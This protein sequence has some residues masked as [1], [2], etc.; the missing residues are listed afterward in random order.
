MKNFLLAVGKMCLYTFVISVTSSLVDWPL[1]NS[2]GKGALL[3]FSLGMLV[4]VGTCSLYLIKEGITSAWKI[5]TGASDNSRVSEGAYY[6]REQVKKPN[7]LMGLLGYE[8]FGPIGGL[9][10]LNYHPDR[11]K[12]VVIDEKKEVIL[13]VNMSGLEMEN[14]RRIISQSMYAAQRKR[15]RDIVPEY[16]MDVRIS[17]EKQLDEELKVRGVE[18]VT[19]EEFFRLKKKNE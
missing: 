1:L 9:L 18:V 15:I 13:D 16:E 8:A 6:V 14:G 7:L 19:D 3:F 4:I 2:I 12:E 17:M 5:P 11:E 10:G